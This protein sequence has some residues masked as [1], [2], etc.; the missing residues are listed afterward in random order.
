MG[1]IVSESRMAVG[2]GLS[3][4]AM[5]NAPAIWPSFTSLTEYSLVL[6]GGPTLY[7]DLGVRLDPLKGRGAISHWMA[8][9]S[10]TA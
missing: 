1:F 4:M 9:S 6:P 5:S 10:A 3:E 7:W 8:R 2:Q